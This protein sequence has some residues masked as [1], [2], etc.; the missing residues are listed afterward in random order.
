MSVM[1][2]F[3]LFQLCFE[4]S[5]NLQ[6]VHKDWK[7][8]IYRKNYSKIVRWTYNIGSLFLNFVL[9]LLYI[10]LCWLVYLKLSIWPSWL[11]LIHYSVQQLWCFKTICSS[12]RRHIQGLY[13]LQGS[14]SCNWGH[15]SW[16][17]FWTGKYCLH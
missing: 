2:V 7:Y 3:F 16:W 17:D 13:L 11:S 14:S 12:H 5:S 8:K 15:H 4:S 9:K 6:H 1:F 10:L